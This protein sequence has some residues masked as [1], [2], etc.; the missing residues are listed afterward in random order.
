FPI[1][2]NAAI[3]GFVARIDDEREIVA[4]IK[5]K[6]A[7]QQ[8]YTQAL[9]QGY[10]AYL[11]EQ[12][13]ASNDIFTIS[14]GAL[15][16]G[17]QCHITISY[18]S[19]L[20]LLHSSKKPTIRFV[21]PT[22]IAPRYS[23]SHK[24][25]RRNTIAAIDNGAVMISFIPSEQDCRQ[26]SNNVTNE[27]FFVIDCSGSMAGDDKIGLARKA[28]LLFLKSL[29][30]N[31]RFNII[32]FGSK[33]SALFT[34]QV[35]REYNKENMCQ[36]EAM[37]KDMGADLGGTELLM[38]LR[39][40]KENKP[41]ASCVRQIFLL[42][43]GEVSN[44]SEV[45][46]LCRD[47]A[48][49]TRIFS[50]GLGHS[51]SRALVKGLAR[52]TNGYFNFIAPHTNVDIYVAEQ[53]ARALQPSIADVYVKWNTNQRILYKVPEHAPPV[54]VGDRLLFYALLDET[55]PFDH[56]TTVELFVGMQQQP[57]GLARIDHVPSVLGSQFVMRLAAKALLRELWNDQKTIDKELLVNIS[58]K[59]GI[60]CPYTA[61]IGVE[62]RFNT[63]N[64]RICPVA[65][66]CW[67]QQ[68]I[69]SMV[70]NTEKL[71]TSD[72]KPVTHSTR[73]DINQSVHNSSSSNSQ[74][75]KM[76]WPIDEQKLVDRFIELQQ[77]N[78]LWMLTADDVHQLTGKSLAIFSSSVIEKLEKNIQ[79][80]VITTAIVIILLETRCLALKT[81]WQALSNK[82][83]K[84][85]KDLL[86][87]DESK[88]EQL[89]KDIRHQL[90]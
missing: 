10:G 78:G 56:T 26:D 36:A 62:R 88:V 67:G 29:P 87:G 81:L 72:S 45:T 38:P 86:D 77:Y 12:D 73:D 70:Y 52:A 69:A 9:A 51:P 13:E 80:S 85:L 44:V 63:N 30:V 15:K 75:S 50:F 14:V 53:L 23:P 59:Y 83:Y 1:E 76:I 2:E 47:M 18:V 32:R 27:F 6:N 90:Q 57:I 19:E 82:A 21:V 64:E 71:N 3:Y 40:L 8:E 79:Q 35:T 34:D 49:Y 66:T 39:W 61:F 16:P 84:S 20:D 58:I 22:T 54:F 68:V 89:M 41:P 28:M 60:L 4:E 42:T 65:M 37:I 43:D 48:A 11:L 46:N 17:S 25:V 5:E 55:M 74:T 31:C 24:D 33:F 7:A